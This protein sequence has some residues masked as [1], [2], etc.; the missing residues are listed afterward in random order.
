MNNSI[1]EHSG[2][3]WLNISTLGINESLSTGN[4]DLNR[5]TLVAE[6]GNVYML[7]PLEL[8]YVVVASAIGNTRLK[9]V[10]NVYFAGPIPIYEILVAKKGPG[11]SLNFPFIRKREINASDVSCSF[12][13]T[14]C[15]YLENS[16][17]VKFFKYNNY[18]QLVVE[19]QSFAMNESFASVNVH[20]NEVWLVNS[21]GHKAWRRLGV[22][23][24]A[25]KQITTKLTKTFCY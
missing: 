11:I 21:G 14:S 23:K 4:A 2:I 3:T 20:E 8:V 18:I 9:V 25:S 1:Y 17:V 10:Q 24:Q 19:E 5:T 15:W 12:W 16:T 7:D 22:S 13:S 6:S